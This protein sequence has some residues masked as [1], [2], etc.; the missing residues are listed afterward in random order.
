[1]R[2]PCKL[3]ALHNL[4]T[5]SSS[6]LS[7]L[8]AL[9]LALAVVTL[10]LAAQRRLAVTAQ[11]PS[12]GRAPNINLVEIAS[13]PNG[14]TGIAHHQPTNSLLLSSGSGMELFGADGAR[15][16]LSRIGVHQGRLASVRESGS[17]FVAGAVFAGAGSPGAIVRLSLSDLPDTPRAQSSQSFWTVLE[18][19]TGLVSGLY[20]GRRNSP[21]TSSDSSDS[22]GAVLGSD[23]IAV[24]TAGGVWRIDSEGNAR[25]VTAM[26][27]ARS[28]NAE[29]SPVSFEAVT[30]APNDP[31]TYG[32]L[33]GKILAVA[34]RQGLI[35]VIDSGGRVESFD[36]GIRHLNNLLLIPANENLFGVTID[37]RTAGQPRDQIRSQ[38]TIWGAP[39]ADFTSVVGDFLVTQ[40]GGEACQCQPAIWR[41]RWNGAEFEKTRLAE[42]AD[43]PQGVEWGQVT[44]SPFGAELFNET[45]GADQQPNLSLVKSVTDLSGGFIQPGDI[46][47]YTLTLSNP[48][49]RPVGRSFIAEFIPANTD[50]VAESSRI[51]AGANAGAKTDAIDDDQ[52][53]A[54]KSGDRVVQINIGVGTGAGGHSSGLLRGGTL[55]PGESSTII[56]RVT[57]K[58]G[59]SE[60]APIINGA[61]WGAEDIYPGGNSNT[62]SNIVGPP[63]KLEKSVTDLNGGQ[64]LPGDTLEYKL[65]L[66]NQ[67]FNPVVRSFIAEFIPRGVTYVA[68]SVRITAGPNTGPKTDAIDADQVDYYPTVGANGQLN[69]ATG[70]GAGGHDA[71]GALIGGGLAPGEGTTIVFRVTVNPITSA[72]TVIVNGANAGANDVYPIAN[73]NLVSTPISC[74]TIILSPAAGALPAGS[75]GAAYSQTFTQTGGLAPINFSVAAGALPPGLTL[76]ATTGA[77]TGTPT[78]AGD[79]SFTIRATDAGGCAGSAAYM[80]RIGPPCEPPRIIAQP[81]DRVICYDTQVTI[82]AAASGTN[83]R[84]Q[85][86]KNGENIPGATASTLTFPNA[87]GSDTGRYSL[88]VTNECGTVTSREALLTVRSNT[89]I[90]QPVSLVRT[91]GES[92]TF[93]ITV[94]GIG[95]FTLQWRRAGQNIPG[96][97][98]STFTIPSVGRSDEASYDV[99]IT[100]DGCRPLISASATLTVRCLPITVSPVALP[101]GVVGTP[102][103]QTFTQTGGLAPIRFIV[104]SG[105]LVPGLTYDEPTATLAGTPTQAGQF[106]FTITAVDANSC[107]G[108]QSYLLTVTQSSVPDCRQTLCFRSASFYSLNTG[109]PLIPNGSVVIGGVNSGNPVSTTDPLVKQA[110]DEQFGTFNSEFV[111]AQLNLLSASALSSEDLAAV[112]AASLGCYGLQFSSVTLSDG[113]VLSPQSPLSDLM[114]SAA[115]VARETGTERD[116]CIL[117]R[118]LGALNGSIPANV[119]NKPAG[120]VDFSSCQ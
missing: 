33:A 115:F 35:Y 6:V 46:L 44:F 73:S 14:S 24:T 20:S 66:I 87:V 119:C 102:Y 78:Q 30:L 74:R 69:I 110:L 71:N 36:L 39:A 52:V 23:L 56:F 100:N 21:A 55:A 98:A 117:I 107:R 2:T 70:A 75:L 72:E 4:I 112:M 116:K 15:I 48:S 94:T 93:S 19:E 88:V 40:T 97:N 114:A 57:V 26:I 109:T 41:V 7:R 77:L 16:A 54:F 28:D 27:T 108:I 67:S 53:D 120:P 105:P 58:T 38:G 99:V 92:A 82:F 96:A 25:R 60:G 81:E 17:G 51:T 1:M 10:A 62:V 9:G 13:D 103:S 18:G 29:E 95:A 64:A 37:R 79:F 32:A 85:W 3:T 113:K 34:G 84:F 49:S 63:L 50:Y 43:A 12:G 76:N 31:A 111:A 106:P 86:R 91:V 65:T 118:L 47:E 68:N 80:L 8:V 90:T 83:L 42:I 104:T 22:F 101:V 45:P 11:E 61:Q 5:R 59:L 89:I